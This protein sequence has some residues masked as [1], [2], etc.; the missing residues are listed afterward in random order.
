MS[1]VIRV[2]LPRKALQIEPGQRGELPLTIQNLSEIVDQYTVDVT[3]LDPSWLE[4]S[5][6]RISLFPQDADQVAIKLHPPL[7]ARAGTYELVV[8]VRSREN[9]IER[10]QVEAT[11]DVSAV[12]RY[13][14][15]L[16]PQRK[17]TVSNR[18]TFVMHL[19][20]PGNVDANLR[21]SAKDPEDACTYDFRPP[22][23]VVQ[24][25]TRMDVP[26]TVTARQPAPE[27]G[28]LHNFTIEAFPVGAQHK[29][30]TVNGQLEC[31]ARVVSLEMSLWPPRR[32]AVG[33][34]QFQVQLA[35]RGN[36]ELSL[37]LDGTDP[38]EACAYRFDP[39]H[40]MLGAGESRQVSLTVAPIGRPPTDRPQ[41]YDFV[42]RALPRGAPHKAAQARGQ[43]ECLPVVISFDMQLIPPQ[44][45][46][47]DRAEFQV[48]LINRCDVPLSL[49]LTA[50]DAEG[51]CDYVFET[52]RAS[53][54]PQETRTVWLEVSPRE[55]PAAGE[56]RS[57]TID[58]R[59]IPVDAPHLVRSAAGQ[60]DLEQPMGWRV[61]VLAVLGFAL[62]GSCMSL[63][64]FGFVY[65][66]DWL[67]FVLLA[68]WGA[69]GGVSLG[70]AL[71]R[72][73]LLAGLAGA[74]GFAMGW[75]VVL[76]FYG[77]DWVWLP[78]WGGLAGLL[79]G[80]ALQFGWR[81]WGL[82]L[83]GAGTLLL[84]NRGGLVGGAIVG[85]A[86]GEAAVLLEQSRGR[87]GVTSGTEGTAGHPSAI[88]S[89][90]RPE[91]SRPRTP[92]TA[93]PSRVPS[94]RADSLQ[95]GDRA[96]KGD[97]LLSSSGE[98][99]ALLP[100][101]TSIG[102]RRTNAVWVKD[103]QSSRFHAEIREVSGG[104]AVVDLGSTN[105]TFLNGERLRP[106]QP[107][108]LRTGDKIRLGST[109]LTLA[110]RADQTHRA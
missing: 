70:I 72:R 21:L 48:K 44:Q 104:L 60:L 107:R 38:A 51:A 11:I 46:A 3:G 27:E 97:V 88:P 22:Q 30:R 33:A 41:V 82:A 6:S 69:L 19:S 98:T 47:R 57:H 83:A 73:V 7:S 91:Y 43:L 2:A 50:N 84:F 100:G 93:A 103:T 62:G 29:A 13:D 89:Q 87:G 56:S 65:Q 45:T 8:V 94:P 68:C 109:T 20:N 63:I 12:F 15:S 35:N 16:S 102:R 105:G 81:S 31:Q 1:A 75:P 23:L 59:A 54:P 55:K 25:G 78:V 90:R 99:F 79:L 36:T 40:V 58:V 17:S 71:R 26:L 66:G 64:R 108:P 96:A 67:A 34:G 42:V 4:V 101:V 32:S 106:N 74:I 10:T 18:A 85:L 24:A 52:Q 5:P 80:L 86:M 49:E 28:K 53:V 37:D 76:S 9:E 95:S 39:G 77:G 14:V 110:R 92:S 61:L